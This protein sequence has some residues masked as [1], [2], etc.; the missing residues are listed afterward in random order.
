MQIAGRPV[1]E[2]TPADVL[3]LLRLEAARPATARQLFYA[4]GRFME[5]CREAGQLTL[6]PCDAIPKLDFSAFWRHQAA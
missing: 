5:W 2:I 1:S 3:K 6:N 4:F